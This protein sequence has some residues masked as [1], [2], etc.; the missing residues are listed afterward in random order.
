MVLDP[1]T[2]ALADILVSVCVRELRTAHAGNKNAR[3]T[4][5]GRAKYIRQE[6]VTTTKDFITKGD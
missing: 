4:A 3:P 1:H 5:I 6:N 2:K